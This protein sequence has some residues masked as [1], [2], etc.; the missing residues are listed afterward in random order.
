[1]NDMYIENTALRITR[2]SSFDIMVADAG[3]YGFFICGLVIGKIME[4]LGVR[5]NVYNFRLKPQAFRV[6]S[7]RLVSHTP[8]SMLDYR[9]V[10][11]HTHFLEDCLT[12]LCGK[13]LE[14]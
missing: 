14:S 6:Q 5:T 9:R 10:E 11:Y 2:T 3:M 4:L 13:I 12:N 7:L 1:M 8:I